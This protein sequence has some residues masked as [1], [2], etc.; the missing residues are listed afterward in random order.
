MVALNPKST[1]G[2]VISIDH[3]K[4]IEDMV[5]RTSG[6]IVLGGGRLT[7]TSD[8]DGFNLSAGSFYSPTVI[9]DIEEDDELWR[10]EVFGPVIV[11]RKFQVCFIKQI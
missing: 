3:L 9:V 11:V 4:R 2:T 6:K 8:L 1:M 10:E 7:G 5:M